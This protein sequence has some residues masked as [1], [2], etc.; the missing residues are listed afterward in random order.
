MRWGTPTW[1]T[2]PS[3]QSASAAWLAR[4]NDDF[5]AVTGACLMTPRAA[6]EAVGGLATRFPLS[7]NDVDYCLKLRSRGLRVVYDPDTVLQPLT[8]GVGVGARAVLG[9]LAPGRRA[10]PLRQPQLPSRLTEHG[11]AQLPGRWRGDDLREAGG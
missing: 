11:A 3:T 1:R 8:R 10:R 7:F 6:F 5:T 2:S 4:S 9:P